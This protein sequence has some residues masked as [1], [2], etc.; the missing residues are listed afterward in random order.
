M[1]ELI[2]EIQKQWVKHKMLAQKSCEQNADYGTARKLNLC[3]MFKGNETLEELIALMFSPQGA[4]FLTTYD[5]PDIATFRKFKKYH[6]ERLGVYID[7]GNIAISEP[8]KAFMVGNTT[9]Q[10]KCDKTQSNRIIAMCGASVSVEASGYAV[11]KIEK[12]SSSKVTYSSKD[13][14]KILL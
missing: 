1:K 13:H 12:D 10:I 7:C 8:K 14:S 2:A 4:E 5:F 9:A 3:A 6:P 11:V